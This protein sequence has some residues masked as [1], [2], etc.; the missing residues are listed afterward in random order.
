MKYLVLI[1]RKQIKGLDKVLIDYLLKKADKGNIDLKP[2]IE[3]IDID[4][5]KERLDN[6]EISNKENI[7]IQIIEDKKLVYIF[8][9]EEGNY[10]MAGDVLTL[11]DNH[12]LMTSYIIK[13]DYD[14]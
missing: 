4:W 6:L 5:I 7:L 13:G 8:D 12:P 10:E 14:N 9:S 2:F 11:I 3:S 1:D